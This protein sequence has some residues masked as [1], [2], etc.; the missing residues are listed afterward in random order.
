MAELAHRHGGQVQSDRLCDGFYL[1]VRV[2]HVWVNGPHN[3]GFHKT[4]ICVGIP[5]RRQKSG[6]R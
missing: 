5:A 1:F 2:A 3:A 6:D 4:S